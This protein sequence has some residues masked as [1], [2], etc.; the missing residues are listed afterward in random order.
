LTQ[1]DEFLKDISADVELTEN[2]F[3]PDPPIIEYK[4]PVDPADGVL[5][6]T[7]EIIDPFTRVS[8]IEIAYG[9]DGKNGIWLF[10]T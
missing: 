10:F 5:P 2:V 7:V 6:V 1:I 3:A 4:S 9:P 8:N